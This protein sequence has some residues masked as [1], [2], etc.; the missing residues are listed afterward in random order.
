[1]ID[2]LKLLFFVL[3]FSHQSVLAISP[4]DDYAPGSINCPSLGSSGL[5]R[6]ADGLSPK[7]ELWLKKRDQVTSENLKKFLKYTAKL[8][9]TEFSHLLGNNNDKNSTSYN[10]STTIKI[11]L[12][13]S[14]GGYRAML[15][16]AGQLSAMDNTTEGAS[17]H[18]LGGLLESTTYLAG[19]S[20]GNWLVG[21]LA[22]NNWTSVTKIMADKNKNTKLWNLKYPIYDLGGLNLIK[23]YIVWKSFI[24]EV[25]EK[26]DAKFQATFIDIWGRA[27]SRQFFSKNSQY[28]LATTWSGLRDVPVFQEGRMPLP[29]SVADL[30]FGSY[31]KW[32]NSTVFES[33]PFEFGSWDKAANTFLDIKY[34][35]T[36]L[37]NGQPKNSGKCVAGYDN[38]GFIMGTSSALFSSMIDDLKGTV[39]KVKLLYALISHK[40]TSLEKSYQDSSL[41]NP[42]PFYNSQYTKENLIKTSDKLPLVDG[43]LDLQNVPLLPLVQPARNVDVIFAF[44]NSADT[45]YNWPNG[46]SL[47][48]TYSRQFKE[49]GTNYAFPYV[50]SAEGF[51]KNNFSQ[52]PVFF[53]CDSTNSTELSNI[54]PLVVFIGNAQHSYASNTSTLKLKYTDTE[55]NS[56]IKNGFETASRGNLTEDSTWSGCVGCA[57][58]RRS[59]E[60][61][62]VE[63]SDF[64][65]SCFKDYCWN[66]K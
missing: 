14:G 27:L 39:K 35:G 7:E 20:G 13:F 38:A 3:L 65:K 44:D 56:I 47:A 32:D 33:T 22:M 57:I 29:I 45:T 42:N 15:A 16:G 31:L 66:G 9:D 10:S 58:V 63:Q 23:T 53:G 25:K 26:L 64:C 12:A 8:N 55:R 2:P 19:L 4:T 37:N 30:R 18:G 34:L 54:P 50:P 5:I 6:E 60:R 40:L 43:G 52:R 49:V 61:A 51:V 11:G 36:D 21:T 1:M 59:Q 41:F 28:G 17:K 48:N 62:N 46:S 24:N